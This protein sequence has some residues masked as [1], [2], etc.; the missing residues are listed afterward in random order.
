M[1]W[2][3]LVSVL[4][5]DLITKEFAEKFL[6]ENTYSPLP[7]LK[8]LLIHNRGAAFGL[9]SE[10]PDWFRIPLLLITPVIALAV[11]YMYST[12]TQDRLLKLS[13]GLIGGGALGNFYDRLFLGEVRDFIHLHAGEFYWPAFN[14][15]DASIT[16]GIG[17]LIFKWLRGRDSNPQPGG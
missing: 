11:T 14:V 1:Y 15:A 7:F 17:I 3:V 8:L 10:F 16:A 6:V 12:K 13:M 9:F 5:A 4:V 2:K